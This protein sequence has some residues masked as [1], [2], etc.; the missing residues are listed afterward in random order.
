LCPSQSRIA[1]LGRVLDLVSL[2]HLVI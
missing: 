2:L 1:G